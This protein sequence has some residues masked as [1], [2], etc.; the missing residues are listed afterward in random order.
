M[1]TSSVGA[2]VVTTDELVKASSTDTTAGMLEDKVDADTINIVSEELVRADLTGGVTT[3]GN[4]AT[5]VTNANLTGGVTSVGNASTVVTN[6]NLTGDVTSVGNAST[7]AGFSG[8]VNAN[9]NQ[10][11]NFVLENRTDDTGMT[12]TGQMWFRTDV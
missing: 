11:T 12:A 10:I 3:V 7:V 6:A 1:G 4:A 5:V 2:I 9:D 8:N